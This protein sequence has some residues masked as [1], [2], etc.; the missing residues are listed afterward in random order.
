MRRSAAPGW[1]YFKVN[2]DDLAED[3]EDVISRI[4]RTRFHRA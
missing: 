1:A 4:K 3:F 2:A